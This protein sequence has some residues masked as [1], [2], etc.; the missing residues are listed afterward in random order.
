MIDKDNDLRCRVTKR[1]NQIFGPSTSSEKEKF[2]EA[3]F[4]RRQYKRQG[5][6]ITSGG[7]EL[8]VEM[9][10]ALINNPEFTSILMNLLAQKGLDA[11]DSET[12]AQLL[13]LLK[14]NPEFLKNF[15]SAAPTQE[16]QETI[17]NANTNTNTENDGPAT[18]E[19][20]ANIGL[21][22][23]QLFASTNMNHEPLVHA[24]I[25]PPQPEPMVEIPT[26]EHIQTTP[27]PTIQ[28]TVPDLPIPSSPTPPVTFPLTHPAPIPRLPQS[29]IETPTPATVMRHTPAPSTS[30]SMS[31]GAIPMPAAYIPPIPVR[32]TPPPSEDRVR[33]FGFPPMMGH[34]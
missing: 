9:Y 28:T 26:T 15:L 33:A 1:A 31:Y 14:S 6:P 21:D 34:R 11:S 5:R 17:P 24:P 8:E 22:S 3:E 20:D 4:K 2:I 23:S 7:N 32:A 18:V 16:N 29:G 30:M 12:S 10:S 13:E 25:D 19:F 27:M